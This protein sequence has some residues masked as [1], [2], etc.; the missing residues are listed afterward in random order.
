MAESFSV[1]RRFFDDKNYPRGFSRHGDYTIRE[2]QILEQ[3]GQAFRALDLGERAPA[4]K[5]EKAFVEFCQGKRP[6]ET[7]FE[8]AW[9]KYR[10]RISHSKRVYTLSGVVGSD[11]MEDFSAE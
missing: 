2:S 1:T 8:K 6:A 9:D 5:E 10:S 3:Y 7:P 4:T 11:N